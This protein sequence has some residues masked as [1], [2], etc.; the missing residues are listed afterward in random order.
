MTRTI[1]RGQRMALSELA[2]AASPFHLR[3]GT[4]S[5]GPALDYSCFGL[6]AQ[7]KLSDERYMSFFNQ[8]ETPCGGV[9]FAPTGDGADFLFTLGQLP[10]GIDRLVITATIDGA[11]TFSQIADGRLQC[12]VGGQETA[13]LAF[14][15]ADFSD[16]RAVMLLEIY[17]KDGAW[18][19]AATVQGFN[20]GLA[21]LISHFG[22]AV[23]DDNPVPGPAAEP[24]PAAAPPA[25]V[26]LSKAGQSQKISLD[27]AANRPKKIVVKATW[28]DNGDDSADNDDLDLRVGILLPNGQ[29]RLVSAP[30]FAGDFNAAPFVLHL[31][32]VT[33][34]SAKA[35]ATEVVEVNPNIA[36]SYGGRVALVFSVYSAVANGAVSISSLRPQMRLEYGDQLIETQLSFKDCDEDGDY[37]DGYTYVL[38][39]ALIDDANILL[40][41]SGVFSESGSESTPWLEWHGA[42]FRMTVDGPPYFKTSG[43][44]LGTG[45][46]GQRYVE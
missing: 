4:G 17:R 37:D 43:N 2:P 3:V 13:S 31:G 36:A 40:E 12:L 20:G 45:E 22:G 41:P 38:G 8:P 25:K 42:S 7:G 26:T 5:G 24:A 16:E 15:R 21:A 39:T 46:R 6:D 32:D 33:K 30:G 1:S 34:A 44:F 18:R 11:G 35:R 23:A 27:K 29:M 19:L 28:Q 9:L 10:A 14:A